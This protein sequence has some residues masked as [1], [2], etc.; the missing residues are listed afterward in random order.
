VLYL[1]SNALELE[2]QPTL[3]AVWTETLTKYVRLETMS[4]SKFAVVA[5]EVELALLRTLRAVNDVDYSAEY[6]V[7]LRDEVEHHA[8]A[9]FAVAKQ[10]VAS[11][12][13]VAKQPHTPVVKDV[14]RER[15]NVCIAE[16]QRVARQF[17]TLAA[18]CCRALFDM[19]RNRAASLTTSLLLGDV[20]GKQKQTTIVVVVCV[21]HVNLSV[22][23]NIELSTLDSAIDG[24]MA[25]LGAWLDALLDLILLRCV[26]VCVCDMIRERERERER[27]RF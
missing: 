15:L 20:V 13:S 2:Y 16:L 1:L 11:H 25:T 14:Q 26:C 18:E 9:V 22:A 8:A 27:E 6:I 10:P 7:R 19:T 21:N 4:S 23:Y 5:N 17:S 24:G 12:A 3:Q